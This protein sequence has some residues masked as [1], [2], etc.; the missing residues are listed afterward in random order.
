VDNSEK[1]VKTGPIAEESRSRTLCFSDSHF[2]QDS[3]K[4]LASYTRDQVNSIGSHFTFSID[5]IVKEMVCAHLLDISIK[6]I[7]VPTIYT[8]KLN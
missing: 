7:I 5:I 1:I 6:P 4:W 2:D 3:N 8:T